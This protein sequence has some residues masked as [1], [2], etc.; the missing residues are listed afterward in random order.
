MKQP[1][2]K[3]SIPEA[4][5]RVNNSPYSLIVRT[6]T[7]RPHYI[8]VTYADGLGQSHTGSWMELFSLCQPLSAAQLSWFCG[9]FFMVSLT[10]W[11][12]QSF[13]TPFPKFYL[14]FG[15]GFVSAYLM[16]SMLA[17]CLQLQQSNTRNHFIDF[18][19]NCF[20]LYLR[21]LDYLTSASWASR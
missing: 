9:F 11:L 2:I 15:C 17:S 20:W 13:L 12:W 1:S 21:S 3:K 14:M 7:R 5:K 8:A 10:F 6:R 18:F 4:N 16:A 19:P